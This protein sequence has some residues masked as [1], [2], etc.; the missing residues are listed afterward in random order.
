MVKSSIPFVGLHAH[1]TAGSPFDAIGFPQQHMDFA[2]QNGSDALALTD[3]GN[4]NGLEKTLSPFTVSKPIL[5]HLLQNGLLLMKNSRHPRSERK[6][7]LDLDSLLKMSRK[8]KQTKTR[9]IKD[10]I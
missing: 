4:C 9:L 2:Y 1:S 10:H 8:Q 7:T 5:S 6:M 3:H